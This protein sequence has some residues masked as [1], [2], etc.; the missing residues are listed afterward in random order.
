MCV[1]YEC[2][3]FISFICFIIVEDHILCSIMLTVT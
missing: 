3:R 1:H 2:V